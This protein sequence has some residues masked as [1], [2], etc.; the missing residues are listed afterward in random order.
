MYWVKNGLSENLTSENRPGEKNWSMWKQLEGL[1][2]FSF[3]GGK[4][5]GSLF[6]WNKRYHPEGWEPPALQWRS[7]ERSGVQILQSLSEG[8][9]SI[10]PSPL[11]LLHSARNILFTLTPWNSLPFFALCS[12]LFLFPPS[13]LS[14]AITGLQLHQCVTCWL[15][16]ANPT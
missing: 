15:L 8:D 10:P 11:F 3:Q 5:H 12:L 9:T 14:P 1:E 7:K 4:A 2:A 16:K 6:W 13:Y